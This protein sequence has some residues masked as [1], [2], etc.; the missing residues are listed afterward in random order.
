MRSSCGSCCRANG[1]DSRGSTT[2]V[3]LTLSLF[4]FL[5]LSISISIFEPDGAVSLHSHLACSSRVWFCS[6]GVGCSL[7]ERGGRGGS[8]LGGRVGVAADTSARAVLRVVSGVPQ[9]RTGPNFGHVVTMAVPLSLSRL[10]HGSID[11]PEN[12]AC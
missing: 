5:F 6:M 1:P 2:K 12:A 10:D 3:R 8:R 4:L 11:E 9:H 7:A